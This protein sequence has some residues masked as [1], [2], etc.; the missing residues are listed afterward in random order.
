MSNEAAH[1]LR[2]LLKVR[3]YVVPH[4][5][6]CIFHRQTFFCLHYPILIYDACHM[7]YSAFIFRF[8]TYQTHSRKKKLQFSRISALAFELLQ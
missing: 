3:I 2:I 7:V 5:M 4:I 1:T 8:R 6:D